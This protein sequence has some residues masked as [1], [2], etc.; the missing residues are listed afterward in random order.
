MPDRY[1]PLDRAIIETMRKKA[2]A[3]A[4]EPYEMVPQMMNWL[5]YSRLVATLEAGL[6][7]R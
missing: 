7:K 6:S 1:T 5:W 4:E 2:D 3:H